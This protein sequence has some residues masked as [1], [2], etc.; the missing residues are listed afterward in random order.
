MQVLGYLSFLNDETKEKLICLC[1]K[2][3]LLEDFNEDGETNYDEDKMEDEIDE[4][5]E[6]SENYNY[7]ALNSHTFKFNLNNNL[8]N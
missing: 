4:E 7:I 1:L 5:I 3:I 8:F 2:R 6:I